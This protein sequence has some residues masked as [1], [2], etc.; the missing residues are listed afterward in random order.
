MNYLGLYIHIPFCLSKC[1]YCDFYSVKATERTQSAY[2]DALLMQMKEYTIATKDKI[3]DTVFIGGGT[4]TSINNE[5]LIKIIKTAQKR[6]NIAKSCEITVEVNPRTIDDKGLKNLYKAGVNRLSIGLQSIHG[7]ELKALSRVH[8]FKDFAECYENSVQAGFE[9][10]NVDLMYGIPNQ[11]LESFYATLKKVV[12]LKPAHISVYGL[13]I[14]PGTKFYELGDNLKMLLPDEDTEFQMYSMCC[15][16]L[17]KSGY[18]HYEI[19]NFARKDCECKHNLKYWKCME[20]VGLG[21]S[22]HSY[23]CNYRFS[24]KKDIKDYIKS[25]NY[26]QDNMQNIGVFDLERY[27]LFDEHT[28]IK[29]NER[30]GEFIMLGFRLK[31]GI[32]KIKFA[33]LFGRDFDQLYYDRIEPFIDSGHI[34]R[35]ESGYA[36][37]REGMFVSNY[38]LSRILDFG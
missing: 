20:Y 11:T 18:D 32:N 25:F 9:N 27:N 10:I 28:E 13:K 14:E 37:S 16:L 34:I 23:F 19:S 33:R 17:E 24:F 30:V 31:N 38:I 2:I 36:F 6:F 21:V 5:D 29:P 4:P 3:F 26:N 15:E 7:N 22:A 8:S 12:S 35:T 1:G